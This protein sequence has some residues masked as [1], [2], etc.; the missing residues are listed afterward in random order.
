MNNSEHPKVI[1]AWVIV[2]AVA[3]LTG[4]QPLT[5][6]MYLPALPQMQRELQMS[7]AAAQ[8]TLSALILS[9]GVGQLIWGPISDRWG[10]RWVLRLGL[11]FFLVAS[12]VTVMAESSHTMVLARA[13]QGAM[14]SA[15]VMCGRAMIRDLFHPEEGARVMARGMTG[16]GA[17]AL[18]GPITGGLTATWMGWRATMT[19]LAMSSAGILLFVWVYLPE[20]LPADRRKTRL[21][22]AHLIRQWG[23]IAR[24]RTF[25]AHALLTSSTY[26]GLFVYLS[27]SSFAFINVLGCSRAVFGLY[28]STLSLSYLIGTFFCRRWLP[29]HGLIGTVK[30]AGWF[31]LAGG[32][33]MAL[34]SMLVW[35][36]HTPPSWLLLPGMWLYAFAHGIHQPCGQTGVV[37]AFPHQAGSASALSGFILASIAFLVGQALAQIMGALHLS[38]S[39]HPMTLGMT[40]GG[41][42]TAW[43]AQTLVSR[44]GLP[45]EQRV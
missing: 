14:L 23:G 15:T 39:L 38:H 22:W 26:G 2:T 34:M 3:L 33:Y 7:S 21:D 10:R 44:H 18:L 31:S 37:S 27:L 40:A 11:A 5:T 19:A 6:D 16:L 12:L 20:T 30:L 36:G 28:M 24:H 1:Q 13:A 25:Q 8:S 42:V 41:A 29:T 9:F 17:L 35:S 43:V 32:L 4:L 45:Q